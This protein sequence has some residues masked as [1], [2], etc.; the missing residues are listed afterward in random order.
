ME[1]TV[2]LL[3]GPEMPRIGLGTSPMDDTVTEN[4]VT[5]AL[6]VGYRSVDTAENY[7]NEAG[8]GR[9]IRASGV[10]REEIFV[11]SKFN[12][13]WHGEDLVA[14]AAHRSLELMGLDY[15][16]LYLIHWP[17]PDQDRY[18]DAWRGLIRLREEGLVR[19]IGVSNFKVSHLRRI[20]DETGVTPDVNQIEL[21]PYTQ[22]PDQTAFGA[23]NRIVQTAWSPLGRKTE[24]LDER[25]ITQVAREVDRTP[26]QV[27]LR[28]HLQKN[29][30][31][32]PKTSNPQRLTENLDVFGFELTG[33][34][35]AQIDG[36][37]NGGEGAADSDTFGH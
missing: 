21:N 14:K 37:D 36:L 18:V 19:A 3:S 5:E 15:L 34:Q 22:R 35:M 4:I 1:Q 13:E 24:L 7:R 25:V 11:T 8:V 33:E 28:W 31:A 17:N 12:A 16:D 23:E 9:G 32:I 30:V 29:H 27:V 20:I 10:D 6:Q 2:K 26:A